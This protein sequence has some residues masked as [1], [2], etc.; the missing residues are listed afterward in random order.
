MK[1][2][3]DSKDLK[4]GDKF[5]HTNSD[6]PMQEVVSK[7]GSILSLKRLGHIGRLS[8]G[9]KVDVKM[10]LTDRKNVIDHNQRVEGFVYVFR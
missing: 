10:K 3:I 1:M 2:F 7:K 6:C 4:V 5:S 8:A 9:E